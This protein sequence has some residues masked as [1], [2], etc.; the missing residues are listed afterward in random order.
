EYKLVY[1]NG[2]GRAELTR[3]IF[4][5]GG[6]PYIDERY[7]KEEWPEKKKTISGGKLPVLIVDGK[8]LPQS[9]AIARFA[10]KKAGIVPDDDLE[11]AYCDALADTLFELIPEAYKILMSEKSEEEKKK[12]LREEFFP[13]KVYPITTRLE[14]RFEEKQW[15]VADKITWADLAIGMV[16][17]AM[18]RVDSESFDKF[19]ALVA[20]VNKVQDLPKI[21]EWLEKRPKTKF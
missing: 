8:T 13:D 4:A 3:W 10:A 21:K 19:P 2:R 5:Y 17:G 6:I 15:F 1:F 16:I 18:L 7:E 20:H 11:A 9:L 14:K 12:L